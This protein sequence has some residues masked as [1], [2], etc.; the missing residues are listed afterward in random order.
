MALGQTLANHLATALRMHRLIDEIKA[1]VRQRS[2]ALEVLDRLSQAMAQPGEGE[3]ALADRAVRLVQEALKAGHVIITRETP[4]DLIQPEP[5]AE[6]STMVPVTPLGAMLLETGD[7]QIEAELKGQAGVFGKLVVTHKVDEYNQLR[8]GFTKGAKTLLDTMACFVAMGLENAR[9]F[10]AEAERRQLMSVLVQSAIGLSSSLDLQV[11][12]EEQLLEQLKKLV[13]YDTASVWLVDGDELRIVAKR[14]FQ[15][16]ESDALDALRLSVETNI[17]FSRMWLSY[18][19]YIIKDTQQQPV[20]DDIPGVDRIRSWIGAP[21]IYKSEVIGHISVD[22]QLPNQYGE[23][24]AQVVQTFAQQAVLAIK[25][26]ESYG[27]ER[28]WADRLLELNTGL[29]GAMENLELEDR[30]DQ[31]VTTAAKLFGCEI[32]GLPL[33]DEETGRVAVLPNHGYIG[34]DPEFAANFRFPTVYARSMLLSDKVHTIEDTQIQEDP[35]FQ[36][37]WTQAI[38]AR[39]VMGATLRAQKEPLGLLY[40]ASRQPRKFSDDE[41]QLFAL[42][43]NQAAMII[44]GARTRQKQK[45]YIA[46]QELLHQISIIG[47]K[48]SRKDLILNIMLTGITAHYGLRFNRAVLL[49]RNEASEELEGYAAI[50]QFGQEEA[51][52]IWEESIKHPDDSLAGYARQVLEHGVPAPTDLHEPARALRIPIQ[53]GGRG[54]INKVVADKRARIIDAWKEDVET[55]F[56]TLL[57]PKEF[58]LVPLVIDDDVIGVLAA[59]NRFSGRKIGKNDLQLLETFANQAAAAI[60][61]ARL[62]EQ[63]ERRL[64]INKWLVELSAEILDLADLHEVF[65][66]TLEKVNERL[67]SNI[68]RVVPY[69]KKSKELMADLAITV[70]ALDNFEHTRTFSEQ[71]LTNLVMNNPAGLVI[72]SNLDKRQELQSQFVRELGV[73]S[74]AVVR[75]DAYG[76]TVGILYVN[77]FKAHNFTSDEIEVLTQ[78]ADRLAR[79]I[80]TSNR[81]REQ[82]REDIHAGLNSI[83]SNLMVSLDRT[84]KKLLYAG[85]DEAAAEVKQVWIKTNWLYQYFKRVMQD[86]RNPILIEQGLPAAVRDLLEASGASKIQLHVEGVSR[87][88][89]SKVELALYR[90]CYEAINNILKHAGGTTQGLIQL[91]IT[92]RNAQLKIRDNGRGW[93]GEQTTTGIGWQAMR[94]WA[95]QI[96]ATY[97]AGVLEGGGVYIDV[98]A[99]VN[100]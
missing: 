96:Q 39:A 89:S 76:E 66:R 43:T 55:D 88:L 54:A 27:R 90:I 94:N 16:D 30:A 61:R 53:L 38:D 50:G 79:V 93:E 21:L 44:R 28:K 69:N 92:P 12:L 59:D 3:K 84:S 67:G 46:H 82:V 63:L 23:A 80:G 72:I 29:V 5:I 70:P 35:L 15:P 85:H 64:E 13:H 75:L 81:Q 14:G 77:Y 97:D 48:T 40:V 73:K 36:P 33:I 19:P 20:L 2:R 47:Q 62:V 31:L 11:V 17:P 87:R 32:V 95:T 34:V 91:I 58:A 52:K 57:T 22:S 49:L 9:L 7:Q 74:T 51:R 41:K 65:S 71:G 99:S 83:Q 37:K 26:A 18:T 8:Q 56:R 1:D 68:S 60:E 86:V 78:A 10:E 4:N 45:D 42:L 24:E 98:T 100:I 6:T 25:N